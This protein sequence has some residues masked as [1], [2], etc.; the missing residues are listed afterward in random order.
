MP[1]FSAMDM[2]AGLQL[3]WTAWA[4]VS[5]P[6]PRVRQ[7]LIFWPSTFSD[8]LQLKEVASFTVPE[9]RAAASVTILNTDP[10][11]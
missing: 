11:S 4:S 1:I 7:H 5:L 2:K 9:S 10:G 3:F 6:W 8:P